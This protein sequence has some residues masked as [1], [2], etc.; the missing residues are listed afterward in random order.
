M[1]DRAAV[2]AWLDAYV[3]AW[4][5][6]DPAAIGDLF[7]PDAV[8]AFGPFAE[9]VRGRETIVAAWLVDRDAPGTYRARYEP[10]AVEGD[11]AVANGRS[12]YFGEDGTTPRTEYDNIFVL[13][14]GPDGRCAEF[15]EW[16][17]ERPAGEG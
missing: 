17:M 2:Q 7:A 11:L 5:S 13:R 16:Y 12:R 14:F 1:V 3:R 15:R 8:Y 4:E 9:P 6:Y 10:L